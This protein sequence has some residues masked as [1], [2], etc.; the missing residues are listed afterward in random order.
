MK[1]AGRSALYV[2]GIWGAVT[3]LSGIAALVGYAVF[4]GFSPDVIAATTALAA[5]AMLSML[6][7][8]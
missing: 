8:I 2:F 1:E 7:D 6:V 3:L 4:Q 5:C